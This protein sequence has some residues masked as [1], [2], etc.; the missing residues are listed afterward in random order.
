MADISSVVGLL[1][2]VTLASF[3]ALFFEHLCN[4]GISSISAGDS[5]GTVWGSLPAGALSFATPLPPILI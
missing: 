1:L 5:A 3:L 2:A 4:S